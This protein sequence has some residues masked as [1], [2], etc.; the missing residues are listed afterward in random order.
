MPF[1]FTA[2]RNS[3]RRRRRASWKP[4]D[5]GNNGKSGCPATCD[6]VSVCS[7]F[8]TQCSSRRT[9]LHRKKYKFVKT[10]INVNQNIFYEI[11]KLRRIKVFPQQSQKVIF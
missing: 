7:V 11:M 3:A 10:T 4:L 8:A 9:N 6:A 1:A 5:T 2:L